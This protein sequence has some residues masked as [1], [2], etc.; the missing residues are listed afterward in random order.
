MEGFLS[1]D[2]GFIDAAY[3]L[4]DQFD[5]ATRDY[6]DKCRDNEAFWRTNHW[7][8]TP[9]REINEPQP[10]T[11]TMFSTLESVLADLM[12]HYPDAILLGE[13]PK[14]D[15][16]AECLTQLV[17]FVLKRR[18]YRKVYRAKCRAALMKGASAQEIYWDEALLGGLGDVAIREWDIEQFYWDPKFASIQEGRAV[19]KTGWYPR[20]WFEAQYPELAPFIGRDRYG[21]D[22]ENQ[23]YLTDDPSEDVRLIEY[24][25]KE[26]DEDGVQRVHMAKMAGGVLLEDSRTTRPEGMYAHGQYPFIVEPLYPL[27]GQPVGLG[28]IDILKNLQVYAD[29]LDQIILKNA[30]MSGKYK[31]LINRAA[32]VDEDAL[33]DMDA[34][35]VRGSRIDEGAIRWMQAQPLSGFVLTYQQAKLAAIKEESGQN[36][37]N[38]GEAGGGITAASAIVALQEAGSK[39][40]RVLIDQ[41]FDGYEQMVRMMVAV[42]Q[43]NY[44][45]ERVFRIHGEGGQKMLRY[46]GA[47]E[48]IDFD[49]SIQVQK[50]TPYSKLYQNELAMQLLGSGVIQ[51]SD[52][53]EMMSFEGRERILVKVLAREAAEQAQR[54]PLDQAG[55][56]PD[57][58]GGATTDNTEAGASTL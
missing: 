11:P 15:R 36:L 51:P 20:G 48:E 57:Q 13:E 46:G 50:Q 42:I 25:F 40:S 19:F 21:R 31:L 43:E 58:V 7:H 9:P 3:R 27:T 45:E 4:L 34:E 14:D 41:L 37:F 5:E 17:R 32:D 39:R 33:T 6:R 29:K 10:V 28:L 47:R 56:V 8:G 1:Q 16:T 35:V 54:A 26:L 55:A 24:W 53:L 23:P 18:N 38:R 2:E 52:A 12:D 30:L 49:V 22:R 44:T